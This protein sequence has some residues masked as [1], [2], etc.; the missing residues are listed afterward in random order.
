L[1]KTLRTSVGDIPSRKFNNCGASAKAHSGALCAA[2]QKAP[3]KISKNENGDF[4]KPFI[5]RQ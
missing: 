1:P 2:A 3:N 5:I 4:T